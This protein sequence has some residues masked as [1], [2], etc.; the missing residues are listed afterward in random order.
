MPT[1]TSLRNCTDCGQVDDHPRDSVG[2]PDGSEAFHHID[3]GA[4]RTPPCESC[5]GQI[6]RYDGATGDKLRRYLRGE[7]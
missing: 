4:R 3:C 2:L 6:D 1:E 7:A 5:A